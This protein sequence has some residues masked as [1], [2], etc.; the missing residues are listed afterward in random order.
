[1]EGHEGRGAKQYRKEIALSPRA[2][3]T[4]SQIHLITEKQAGA[5]CHPVFPFER[6]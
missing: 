6:F 5:W 2:V 4:L 3:W 1:M